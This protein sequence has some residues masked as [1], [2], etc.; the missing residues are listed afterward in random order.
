LT[1][2]PEGGGLVAA[3]DARIVRKKGE[4]APSCALP[5]PIAAIVPAIQPRAAAA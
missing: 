3:A 5:R 4:Y 1:G 2:R